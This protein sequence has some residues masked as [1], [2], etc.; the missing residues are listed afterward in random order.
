MSKVVRSRIVMGAYHTIECAVRTDGSSPARQF[1]DELKAGR[2]N[3]D[4]ELEEPPDD[5]QIPDYHRFI[6]DMQYLANHG[7]P[8][9]RGTVNYLEDGVWEFKCETKR[10]TFWDVDERGGFSPKAKVL[11]IS[12]SEY[13]N[14]DMWWFPP[15][16]RMLRLG[17]CWLKVDEKAD[18]LDIEEAIMIREED[19]AY[20][21]I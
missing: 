13:P 21:A 19:L 10:L 3:R 2:W 14:S 11:D 1:L 12:N 16:D 5:E 17:N 8:R 18:P 6:N 9:L 20:D 15:M 7:E 4:Q